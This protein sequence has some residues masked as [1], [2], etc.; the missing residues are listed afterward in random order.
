MNFRTIYHLF[1][2]FIVA[3]TISNAAMTVEN[4]RYIEPVNSILTQRE[5]LKNILD[6][7]HENP[8]LFPQE[9]IKKPRLL[10]QTE[11]ET[12]VQTWASF[13]EYVIAL[14]AMVES[15][16][17]FYA[18][19][20]EHRRQAFYIHLA[21]FSTLYR[22]SMNFI[23]IVELDPGLD[24][25]LNEANPALGLTKGSYKDFKLHYLN[26]A[27]AARFAALDILRKTAKSDAPNILQSGIDEDRKEIWQY[28]KGQGLE[29]TAIN[30]GKVVKETAY[31]ALFPVQKGV[32]NWAGNIRVKRSGVA[33][34]SD[35][36]IHEMSLLFEPGDILLERREWYLTNVGI[37]G[38]WPHAALYI[39]TA[40]ERQHY[41]D[42]EAV[43]K[44]VKSN[45]VDSGD[46]EQLLQ[47]TNATAYK[48]SL[49]PDHY[50]QESGDA[51]RVI[52]AIANGVVFT[53][54]E[55]SAAADSI[56]ALRP[57]LSKLEVAKA[58]LK[59][60]KYAGRPYDY[61]F[62]FLTDNSMVCSELV[63]KSYQPDENQKGLNLPLRSMAGKLIMP[64]NEIARLYANQFGTEQQQMDLILFL[65]GDEYSKKSIKSTDE[66]FRKSW[67]RPKWHIIVTKAKNQ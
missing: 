54:L 41:F 28:G 43:G 55:H 51:T 45:G 65:D 34:I 8:D 37:P 21:A 56:A 9:K 5:G 6:Y 29:L 42:D 46:F 7:M 14:E 4:V 35:K 30:A 2:Y 17:K 16:S 61:N 13:I 40:K 31:S 19:K 53:S 20:T 62:D 66:A 24:A 3:I 59:A 26:A 1:L 33:L 50:K 36:Q 57:R 15:S 22:Y 11:R 38:F 60:F 10:S 44:W 52:E 23:D 49:E 64:A 67:H 18:F 27:I 25:L 32:A 12:I 48:K 47:K 39:G 63:Y 58:I